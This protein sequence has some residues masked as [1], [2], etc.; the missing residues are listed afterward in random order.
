MSLLITTNLAFADWPQVWQGHLKHRS[1]TT[2]QRQG[3][4]QPTSGTHTQNPIGQR[5]RTAAQ[6]LTIRT[7]I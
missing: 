3:T 6:T 5:H 4:G 2:G 1:A 7:I